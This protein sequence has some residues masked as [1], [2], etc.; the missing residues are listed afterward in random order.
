[1]QEAKEREM[2]G[3]ARGQQYGDDRALITGVR[4]KV[5]VQDQQIDSLETIRKDLADPERKVSPDGLES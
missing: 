1:M 4:G 3:S 2:Y 5:L